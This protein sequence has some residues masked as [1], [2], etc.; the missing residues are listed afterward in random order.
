MTTE[1]LFN[2]IKF[3]SLLFLA[4]GM[5]IGGISAI[6]WAYNKLTTQP[7]EVVDITDY[8]QINLDKMEA[9]KKENEDRSI[10]QANT[11]RT[12]AEN[13]IRL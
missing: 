5:T 11:L 7:T 13:S 6:M 10:R 3:I 4:V 1:D 8:N 12:K 9:I 2:Y